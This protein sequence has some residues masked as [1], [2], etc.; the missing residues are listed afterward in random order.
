MCSWGCPLSLCSCSQPTCMLKNT[1]LAKPSTL[2]TRRVAR[3]AD[4]RAATRA[5]TCHDASARALGVLPGS[6]ACSDARVRS[7]YALT[8]PLHKTRSFTTAHLPRC[9]QRCHRA[10]LVKVIDDEL[11]DVLGLQ[12]GDRT[13]AHRISCDNRGA[14]IV[15][16]TFT[17]WC[18]R[19][20]EYRLRR[21]F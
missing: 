15:S 14:P 9:A 11:F 18:R 4:L 17:T 1:P 7:A 12:H 3:C 6:P 5:H 16:A 10:V 8:T 2:L 21:H 19:P 20:A 13:V